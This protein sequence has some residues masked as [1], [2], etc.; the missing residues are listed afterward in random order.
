MK[1]KGLNSLSEVH[2]SVELHKGSNPVKKLM[3]F[4]GPAYLVSVGY[5]DPG[6][7]ATDIAGG[8]SFGYSLIWVLL[9][10][11]LMAL[12]LQTLSARFGVVTG[13][14]LAQASRRHYSPLMNLFLYA[15]AEIAITACDLAE[16]IGMAIGLNLLFG[17]P[18]IWGV[19]ISLFDTFL[20]L[21]LMNRG[22][23]KLEIFIV[24]M[25]LI[26]GFS[27]LVELLISRPAGLPI[28]KGFIPHSLNGQSLYIAI[29]IIGAT[30]MPHNLYLHSSLVQ[31]R[32]IDH[33]AKGIREALRYNFIDT[34]IALNIAFVVNMAI[35]ILA[36]SAFYQNGFQH[37]AELQDAY[38][39][40][41][42]LLGSWAPK[43]FALALVASGQSS[44]VTGTLAGQIIMEG[45]LDIK[46]KPWLRRL[47]TRLMAVIPAL[48][49]I[50]YFGDRGLG[51]L[52]VSSQVILSVQLGFAM[53]PLIH[54]TN[55][56]Q[57]MKEYRN[58]NFIKMLAWLCAFILIA[59]N[60]KY[61]LEQT[62]AWYTD[63]SLNL[64]YRLAIIIAAAFMVTILGYLIIEP[65][66]KS[67]VHINEAILEEQ[68]NT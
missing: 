42:R 17:F 13:T 3:A 54:F 57:W 21:F 51:S 43:L 61:I 31:S 23:K 25:I 68:E 27:F 39:L 5:M 37:V 24:T 64:G 20:V 18:L 40:L 22:I 60:G 12:L 29:G 33:S 66:L 10:S 56:A 36:A 8:S 47:I 34:G 9:L 6:N 50:I 49:C 45:Y 11:N 7:W 30:V 44:T 35:L 1:P 15:L 67:R 2:A 53:I 32:K 52:L 63:Q 55:S 19:L 14:D 46:L 62:I 26:I 28:L 41:N 59:L 65:F 48:I 58:T 16:V 4:I 38:K